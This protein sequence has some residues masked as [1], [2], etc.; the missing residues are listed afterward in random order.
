M[1]RVL[2]ALFYLSNR[3]Y[4][5]SYFWMPATYAVSPRTEKLPALSAEPTLRFIF[6]AEKAAWEHGGVGRSL[7]RVAGQCDSRFSVAALPHQYS[8]IIYY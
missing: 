7:A 6:A 1:V 3:C 8:F 4:K 5:I 2:V